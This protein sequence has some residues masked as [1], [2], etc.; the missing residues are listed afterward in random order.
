MK[1]IPLW[2]VHLV[3]FL[4]PLP[5]P[6]SVTEAI[7]TLQH[8]IQ[9]KTILPAIRG[10]K[11]PCHGGKVN[12]AAKKKKDF[13]IFYLCNPSINPAD[14]FPKDMP[15][16][17]CANFTYK[18]K[19]FNNTNCDFAQPRKALELKHKTIIRIANHFI[20]KDVGWLNEYQ[21]E[22]AQH[23]RWCHKASW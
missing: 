12:T 18:V 5:L 15:E 2:M 10:K 8:R 3:P 1:R 13:G 4:S 7:T 23:H 19:E 22:D 17:H 14:I 20:K 6:N 9:T 21:H 16:K 11:K